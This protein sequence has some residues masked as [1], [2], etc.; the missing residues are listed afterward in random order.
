MWK[1]IAMPLLKKLLVSAT[2]KRN[3]PT[4]PLIQKLWAD[5][6]IFL[7]LTI[8]AVMLTGSVMLIAF[9]GMFRGLLVWGIE[10]SVSIALTGASMCLIIGI[11]VI[12]MINYLREMHEIL[13]EFFQ[14]DPPLSYSARA[15]GKSFWSGLRN[16]STTPK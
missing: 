13:R 8:I 12:T 7:V 16:R 4:M 3:L 2:R 6:T 11:L 14:E 15:I 10:P 9:Y 1:V 5:M